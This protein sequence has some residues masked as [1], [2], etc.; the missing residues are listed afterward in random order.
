MRTFKDF[1][2]LFTDYVRRIQMQPSA[3][4]ALRE[5]LTAYADLHELPAALPRPVPTFFERLNL[6][7]LRA[8]FAVL[9]IAGSLGGVAYASHD[10]LPGDPLY[11][12]KVG[13]VEP[14]ETA[15]LYDAKSRATWN[16]ILA[17]RRLTEAA[18]LASSGTLDSATRAQLEE[19][20]TLHTE[21]AGEAARAV[22]TEGDAAVA[23]AIHS[24]L[25]ARLSAHAD[26][27]A[28]LSLSEDKPEAKELLA[29]IASARDRVSA[30]RQKTE[31]DVVTRQLAYE[32][33]DINEA[34]SLTDEVARMAFGTEDPASGNIGA[35][36][37]AA[38]MALSSAR[39]SL[40]NDERGVAFVSAQAAA[41]FTHEAAIIA[42]N[43]GIIARA[44]QPEAAR[45]AQ[46]AKERAPERHTKPAQGLILLKIPGS[47]VRARAP[48]RA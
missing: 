42:K 15:L 30:E 17:E 46:E 27:F 35:R 29:K 6:H 12:I 14:L 5:R 47:D 45:P 39:E 8:G 38:R 36:I 33:A 13:M 7:A 24:D 2:R 32:D 21:R 41:R 18:E 48:Q 31:A 22:L 25:E 37:T 34:E 23:L 19:R 3:H 4:S 40:A 20:L 1:I 26:L 9:V 44:P 16:A 10:A 11:N 28:Y 43:R